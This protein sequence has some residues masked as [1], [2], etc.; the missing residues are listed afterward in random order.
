[1]NAQPTEII[2]FSAA[3]LSKKLT[4]YLQEEEYEVAQTLAALMEGYLEGLW[5]VTWKGGEP[6]FNLTEEDKVSLEEITR[7]GDDLAT[8]EGGQQAVEKGPQDD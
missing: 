3:L 2:D 7:I 6:Y 5:T 8:L 1:M 4:Q